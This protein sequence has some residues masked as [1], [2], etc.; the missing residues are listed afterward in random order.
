MR[1]VSY[2]TP[3]YK[4]IKRFLKIIALLTIFEKINETTVSPTMYEK[5]LGDHQ[6][7]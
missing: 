6:N 2:K 1:R 3:L 7:E 4:V 5:G